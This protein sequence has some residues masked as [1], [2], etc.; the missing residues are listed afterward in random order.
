M[1]KAAI[2]VPDLGTMGGVQTVAEFV[3]RTLEAS[4]DFEPR[5]IS[6]ATASVDS[7]S[8]RLRLP[9]SWLKNPHTCVRTWR[10][11]E[12]TH[13]GADFVEIETQRYRPR[14][15]LTDLLADCDFVQVVAGTPAWANVVRDV[16]QPVALQVA[17]M[18][19]VE[20]QA[21]LKVRNR[22]SLW[23]QL[24]T[25]WNERIERETL[26]RVDAVF[27][28]NQWMLDACSRLAGSSR[29]HLAPPGVDTLVFRPASQRRGEYILSVGRFS[30]PRKNVRLLF[31]AYAQILATVPGAPDLVLAGTAP[32]PEDCAFAQAL[33]VGNRLHIHERV[34]TERLV[35][36]YQQAAVFILA[37]NEEGLGM[38]LL[39]AMACGIPVVSTDCGGPSTAI[40]EGVT[41]HLTQVGDSDALAL[42]VGGVL[43]EPSLNARMGHAARQ[44]VIEQFSLPVAG[45]RFTDA[46]E[47][48]LGVH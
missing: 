15:I 10:G 3:Y 11:I 43:A 32:S 21:R 22:K 45:R 8:S 40:V 14:R 38:V 31:Q 42:A 37:S 18:I 23:L 30:D 17:T 34:N 28:E 39:E 6:L 48:M 7:S 9:S 19:R 36:L 26:E 1:F 24:M 46:Y 20:R 25:A 2:V 5:L 4:P 27:V 16:E 12:Y 29:V 41:G 44:H 47:R 35:E 33:G 13:V